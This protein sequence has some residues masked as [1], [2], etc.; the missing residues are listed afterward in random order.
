M[1]CMY[2]YMC[3]FGQSDA[4]HHWYIHTSG[5]IYI[6]IYLHIFG[7]RSLLLYVAAAV[8][9]RRVNSMEIQL[10]VGPQAQDIYQV[11]DHFVYPIWL[12]G[13]CCIHMWYGTILTMMFCFALLFFIFKWPIV[14]LIGSIA[15]KQAIT[16]WFERDTLL[17][18]EANNLHHSILLIVS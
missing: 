10:F 2:L 18:L 12:F 15:M 9:F 4:C 16:R 6:K 17:N 7:H 3:L 8:V 13:S 14:I 1:Y 5:Y 11:D